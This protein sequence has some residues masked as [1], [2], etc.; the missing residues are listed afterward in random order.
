MYVLSSDGGKIGIETRLEYKTENCILNSRNKH[1]NV[2][3]SNCFL[4]VFNFKFAVSLVWLYKHVQVS[5][6]RYN[7]YKTKK[8]QN[9]YC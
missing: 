7:A 1:E 5:N 9:G 3:L 4:K 8:I 6:I 2:Y